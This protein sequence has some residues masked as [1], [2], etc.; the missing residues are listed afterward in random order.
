[1]AE[2]KDTCKT[3][4]SLWGTHGCEVCEAH[5]EDVRFAG[6]A[7]VVVCP[8]HR[9]AVAR[10]LLGDNKAF[11]TLVAS[12]R[13]YTIQLYMLCGPRADPTEAV[14]CGRESTAAERAME[15]AIYDY[16]E[17]QRAAWVKEHPELNA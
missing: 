5:G 4:T 1:M 12:Q 16:L 9:R 8:I 3:V 14:A 17:Q 13:A 10:W 2:T 7:L 6:V 15:L 11:T